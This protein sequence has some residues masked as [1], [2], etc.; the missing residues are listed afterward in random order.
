MSVE[1]T[2][3]SKFSI[4]EFLVFRSILFSIFCWFAPVSSFS[5]SMCMVSLPS[6]S[7]LQVHSCASTLKYS[8]IFRKVFNLPGSLIHHI[9]FIICCFKAAISF[10]AYNSNNNSWAK[11]KKQV[12]MN[13][14]RST[15][16]M[17][18]RWHTCTCIARWV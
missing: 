1:T 8:E 3:S 12:K 7:S 16:R 10:P 13:P 5:I 6:H 14:P 18:V 9:S 15:N 17:V 2:A 11:E 4:R